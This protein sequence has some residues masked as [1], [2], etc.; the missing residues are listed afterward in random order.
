VALSQALSR[1]RLRN[2]DWEMW[3]GRVGLASRALLYALVGYLVTAVALRRDKGEADSHGALELAGRQTLG[4]VLLFVVGAGFCAYA[5]W[6]LVEAVRAD[7]WLKRA[8]Y[9]GKALIYA[10]LTATAFKLAFGGGGGGGTGGKQRD[11]DLT[12]K[13][14]RLSGGRVIVALVGLAVLAVAGANFWRIASGKYEE[15]LPSRRSERLRKE[16]AVLQP[17][18]IVGL[19]GRGLA[20]TLVGVFIV[21]AAVHRNPGDAGGLDQSLRRL[22]GHTYG[23]PL[24]FLIAA[25]MFAYAAFCVMQARWE[26]RNSSK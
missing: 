9:V 24:L 22:H 17:V 21:V 23:P 13:V 1:R 15:A 6:R 19:V 26:L 11:V 12:A 2:V 20:F 18:A 4:H 16:R 10:S 25:G 14:M 5:L 8:G 7:S 3:L